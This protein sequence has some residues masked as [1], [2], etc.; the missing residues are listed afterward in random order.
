MR[1]RQA[2]TKLFHAFGQTERNKLVV[3]KIDSAIKTK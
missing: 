1:I 2:V 3:N